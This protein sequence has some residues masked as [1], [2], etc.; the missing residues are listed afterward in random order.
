MEL[1]W[2]EMEMMEERKKERERGCRTGYR[3]LQEPA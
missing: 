2:E 3:D 1:Y